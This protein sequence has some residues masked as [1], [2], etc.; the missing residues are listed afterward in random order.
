VTAGEAAPGAGPA[1]SDARPPAPE[2]RREGVC[3]QVV[4]TFFPGPA[5]YTGEDV[6]EIAAH[7]SPVVLAGIVDR[8]VACGARI[9]EPGEFT[10][11]AFLHGKLDL[12]QAEA[13][14]DLVDAV[15]P[16]QARCAFDQL[17]GTLT[18]A[19]ARIEQA[20]FDVTARLEA[21]L[22]FPDEGYHF[23]D[24]GEAAATLTRAAAEID[25]LLEQRARG[26]LVREGAE[27]V[28]AGRPNVGKSSLFNALLHASR[29]I[30]TDVPGTTRDL[31]T[32]RVE[33]GGLLM[34][35]VDTAGL[36]EATDAVEREGVTRTRRALEVADLVLV[37]LDASRPLHDTD[38]ALL[39][40]VAARPHVVVANKADLP[41]AWRDIDRVEM[42]TP[43]AATAT[44]DRGHPLP[45]SATSGEGLDA[46]VSALVS[47]LSGGEERRD[48]PLVTNVRHM[49]QLEQARAALARAIGQLE[50]RAPE[51]LALAD[52]L[53]A[54]RALQEVTGQRT[55]DDLL[56]QI[57]ERFC[58]G[59]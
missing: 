27:V 47:A 8:A 50:A 34:T 3:D 58:I 25:R 57:F 26:R 16:L 52:L 37:V 1:A 44:C 12:V 45:V 22:D 4:V 43:A 11:R 10:L 49:R 19:I 17:E 39:A 15:T 28:I 33:L 41:R 2:A 55:T 29:A 31:L 13:V 46:L 24:P 6:V 56:R 9:A 38:R 20:V 21:S 59:K 5:S 30:V 40:Q 42:P 18:Q 32:E 23:T 53:D 7:G 36:H 35:L 54:S 51:E 14:A 48:P